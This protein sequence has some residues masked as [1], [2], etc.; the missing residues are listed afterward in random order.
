MEAKLHNFH[1]IA[2]EFSLLLLGCYGTAIE[3]EGTA[4]ATTFLLHF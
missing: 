2:Y 1:L 4:P 3:D